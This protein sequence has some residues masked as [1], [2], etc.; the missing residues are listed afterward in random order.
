MG[1]PETAARGPAPELVAAMAE[2]RIYRDLFTEVLRSFEDPQ[3]SGWWHA[4]VRE[5]VLR[6]WHE[7][8]G[9]SRLVKQ[10]GR[11]WRGE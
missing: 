10:R 7:R 6:K 4:R 9:I 11:R 5:S 1:A 8:A 3:H 2:T